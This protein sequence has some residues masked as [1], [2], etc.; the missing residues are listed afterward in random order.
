MV[1]LRS[2]DEEIRDGG[3]SMPVVQLERL[4]RAWYGDRLDPD[5]RPRTREESQAI[6]DDMELTNP[7]WRLS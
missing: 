5:W 6:L 2:E 1:L 4:A 3:A 7:F